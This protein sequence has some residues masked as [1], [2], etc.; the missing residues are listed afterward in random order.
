EASVA[1]AAE[2]GAERAASG[3]GDRTQAG[4][5][6]R[7]DHTHVATPLALDADRRGGEPRRRA[8]EQGREGPEQLT[9]IDRAPGELVVDLHE[10]R[11]RVRALEGLHVGGRGIDGPDERLGVSEVAERLHAARGSTRPDR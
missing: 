8:R 5:A 10:V 2:R 3:P 4:L 6:P 9:A 11:D 1:A 7:H